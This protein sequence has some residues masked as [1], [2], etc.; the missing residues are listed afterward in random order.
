MMYENGQG[1]PQNY[2]RAHMW[3]N[4]AASSASIEVRKFAVKARDAISRL[5]TSQQIAQA[6][7]M[8]QRCTASD[9]TDCS[10]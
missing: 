2:V 4:I 5:M 8:A 10:D 7:Q 9:Y 1:V 6:Q 3:Y